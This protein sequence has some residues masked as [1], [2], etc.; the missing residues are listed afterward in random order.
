PEADAILRKASPLDRD[1]WDAVTGSHPEIQAALLEDM[2]RNGI[3]LRTFREAFERGP[4]K[5]LLVVFHRLRAERVI[6]PEKPRPVSE[7]SQTEVERWLAHGDAHQRALDAFLGSAFA[8]R[9]RQPFQLHAFEAEDVAAFLKDYK[10]RIGFDAEPVAEAWW[11]RLESSRA[12]LD[13]L[14]LGECVL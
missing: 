5:S 6:H 10:R 1:W 2:S 8:S 7:L 12:A 3:T 14:V 13:M 11:E 4:Y 9:M